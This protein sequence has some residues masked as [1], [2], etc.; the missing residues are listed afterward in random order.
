MVIKNLID[1]TKEI[2]PSFKKKKKHLE[3][4]YDWKASSSF[5]PMINFAWRSPKGR[6]YL[7]PLW[8]L[9][10]KKLYDTDLETSLGGSRDGM[11]QLDEK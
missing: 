6:P 8:S 9:S 5:P 10:K 11:N 4:N 2:M 1:R 3:D 7:E